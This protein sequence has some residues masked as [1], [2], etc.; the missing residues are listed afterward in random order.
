M[1]VWRCAQKPGSPHTCECITWGSG[2]SPGPW[3]ASAFPLDELQGGATSIQVDYKKFLHWVEWTSYQKASLP[4]A[5]AL[6]TRPDGL[7]S[8]PRE[9]LTSDLVHYLGQMLCKVHV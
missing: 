2:W 5:E 1:G 3:L 7:P 9:G 6:W 8:D 4:L